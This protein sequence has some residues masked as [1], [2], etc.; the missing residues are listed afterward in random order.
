MKNVDWQWVNKIVY[1]NLR[2]RRD[3]NVQVRKQLAEIAAE[4]SKILR[5]EAIEASPG[6][7]GCVRSHIAVLEMAI[8]EGWENV[9][10]LE[11]DIA[12]CTT[13]EDKTRLNKYFLALKNIRWDVAFLGANYRSVTALN[14]VDYLVRAR[15]AWCACAYLVNRHYMPVLLEN[16]RESLYALDQGAEQSQFALDVHW[17]SLMV[18][19]CWLGVFPNVA[20]QRADKS[21][22]E[23]R[24]VDYQPLFFKPLAAISQACG[25]PAP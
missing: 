14:S 19:D 23:Q 4:K 18:R 11:D 24:M 17:H 7:I 15:Q 22:I 9:L 25:I 1:I 12:F 5:F 8:A 20:Y 3:R 6:Y 13:D 21:D 10:I 2:H 16:F